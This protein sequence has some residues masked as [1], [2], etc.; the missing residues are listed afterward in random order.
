LRYCA[1]DFADFVDRQRPTRVAMR[2]HGSFMVYTKAVLS[3]LL[4]A[5]LPALPGQCAFAQNDLPIEWQSPA[6]FRQLLKRAVKGT[7]LFDNDGI[8]FRSPKVSHRWPYGEIKTFE[9][10]ATRE[11]IITDYEN[12][13]WHEPGERS[14][15]FRLSQPMP[16]GTAAAFA[17]HVGRPVINGDPYP[18]AA[19]IAELPAHHRERFGGSNGT[20]RLRDG[21]IDYVAVDGH[22]G[23]SWRW[24]DIQTLANPNPWEFR[25]M[26]YREIVEF[27][28]KRPL[29]RELFDRL[30][31][32]LY[33]Q[34]LNVAP[35]NGGHRQ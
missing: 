27:D 17:A 18:S 7:L 19:I 22:D 23:R 8:E 33:A 15:R 29:S 35:P 32:S 5:A 28:L 4:I 25:V 24:C 2:R 11:L 3:A 1:L 14:F 21:G 10:S 31:N 34:D 6:Q 30:W 13:H 9:L 12:R 20:L 16:P 26:A